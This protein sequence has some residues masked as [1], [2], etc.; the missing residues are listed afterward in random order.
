V[1]QRPAKAIDGGRRTA[2]KAPTVD[3]H[4]FRPELPM[5]LRYAHQSPDRLRDAVASLEEFSTKSAQSGKIQP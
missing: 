3:R 2:Q 5:T 1:W 4:R